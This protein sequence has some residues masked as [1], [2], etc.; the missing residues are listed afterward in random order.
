MGPSWCERAA[1]S[2][3][4]SL[5]AVMLCVSAVLAQSPGVTPT[6][7]GRLP[8]AS[9]GPG[10]SYPP[11]RCVPGTITALGSTALQPLV[12]AASEA[13][14]AACPGS[15]VTV[16]GGGSGTGL[17]QV[18]TNPAVQIGDSDVPAESK[19]KPEDASQLV[20]HVVVRQGWI[21]ITNPDVTGVTDLSTQQARDIWTGAITNW[22]GVGG[23]DEA[24]VL[25]IR[26]PSSGTRSTFKQIVLGGRDESPD[27]RPAP[28][29]SNA[30]VTEAVTQT[31]GATSVIGFAYYQANKDR[32]N[33]LGLDGVPATVETMAS[34]AYKL[35]ADARMY[36][37]GAPDRASLTAA[38]L[39]YML[40]PSVQQGLAPSLYYAPVVGTAESSP[41]PS[42]WG[43]SPDLAAASAP[44][45]A[46]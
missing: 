44:R 23:P 45:N 25:I 35:S 12:E 31:P 19:L 36:T 8:A 18:L 14:A 33:G 41:A 40:S 13:Y 37:R 20:D 4:L 22:K 11:P 27:A 42:T 43:T 26:P 24:I 21:M 5:L 1:R 46:P 2:I 6:T 32:L 29:D 10:G 38:F 34:G 3:C 9:T 15:T 17:T 39:D 28:Q 16:Q 7:E 30:A